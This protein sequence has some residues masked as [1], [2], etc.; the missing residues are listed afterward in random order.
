MNL[1][2]ER[3]I[4]FIGG[5]IEIQSQKEE[6]TLRGEISHAAIEGGV[7]G[8]II[9]GV[10]WIAKAVGYPRPV[11]WVRE[12]PQDGYTVGRMTYSTENIG[13]GLTGGDRI[14]IRMPLFG[15]IAILCPPDGDRLDYADVRE[16]T[17]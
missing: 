2:H 3:L 10:K 9:I 1:T 17:L 16:Y 5:Q 11:Y 4:E 6:S 12:K 14:L 8:T 15:E 7:N 13:P